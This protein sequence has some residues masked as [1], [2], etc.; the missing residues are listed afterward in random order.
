MTQETRGVTRD[1]QWETHGKIASHRKHKTT[2][3]DG[4]SGDAEGKL[5]KHC[6]DIKQ[7]EDFVFTHCLWRTLEMKSRNRGIHHQHV[8]LL[9]APLAMPEQNMTRT[10]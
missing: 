3:D 6:L 7:K 10:F 1:R 4:E 9:K 8:T 5:L 2:T